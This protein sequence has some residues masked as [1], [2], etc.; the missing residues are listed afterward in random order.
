MITADTI[1]TFYGLSADTKPT[2]ANNGSLFI[3]ID[4]GNVYSFDAEN[5]EWEEWFSFKES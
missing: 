5:E 3:E 4:T 1:Q 2:N